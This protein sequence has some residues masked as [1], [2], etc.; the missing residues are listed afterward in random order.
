MTSQAIS[1]D[2]RRRNLN[3]AMDAYL[4]ARN[5]PD[6]Q[7]LDRLLGRVFTHLR[8]HVGELRRLEST[9]AT[10]EELE[11]RRA[12]VWQLQDHVGELVR[13]TLVDSRTAR[14]PMPSQDRPPAPHDTGRL[15][16]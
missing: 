14:L 3:A 6:V 5:P 9:G 11:E 1:N 15:L 2:V 16:D 12:L 8:A 13:A 4:R 10:R 7:R